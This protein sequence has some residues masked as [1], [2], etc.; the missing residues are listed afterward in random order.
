[1][2]QQSNV[3]IAKSSITAYN[4]K[5]WN[6]VR[7]AITSTAVYD[8]VAT[9]RKVQGA[10]EVIAL[11]K[12]WA[13]ALP[14]SRATFGNVCE[15]GNTVVIELTWR[16]TH[17][18]PLQMPTG[19][20]PATGKKIELRACQV[21]EIAGGKTQAI[22]QYFDMATFLQQLGVTPGAGAAKTVGA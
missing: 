19:P 12:G 10:D 21:I 3:D 11:W 14:D 7:A 16:G 13:T 20:L 2:P 1:M 5:D 4:D 22:R 8:E 17:T 15:S 9:N 6:A 18:G